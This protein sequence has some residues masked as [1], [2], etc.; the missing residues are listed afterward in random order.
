VALLLLS[1]SRVVFLMSVATTTNFLADVCENVNKILC[2]VWQ[3]AVE[4][5]KSLKEGV[6]TLASSYD[7]VRRWVNVI[8]DGGEIQTM[9]FPVG[10]NIG[11]G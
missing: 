5:Y 1:Q 8:K 11:D 9:P 6:G 2:F 3:I 4:C 10:P 7:T